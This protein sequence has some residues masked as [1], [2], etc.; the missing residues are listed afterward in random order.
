MKVSV[1]FDLIFLTQHYCL[2]GDQE[3]MLLDSLM[4]D[5]LEQPIKSDEFKDRLLACGSIDRTKHYGTTASTI[6]SIQSKNLNCKI[7]RV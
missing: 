4:E 3:P 7:N 1:A 5:E 6:P 2:Y